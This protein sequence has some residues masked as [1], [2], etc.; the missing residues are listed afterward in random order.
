MVMRVLLALMLTVTSL[1]AQS[2][3]DKLIPAQPTHFVTDAANLFPDEAEK[4]MNDISVTTQTRL[5]GDIAV[6]TL[7][8]IGDYQPYEVAMTAGR[9]WKV[10][11]KGP[12]GS[13]Q[14]NLGV[15]ILVVP[16]TAE[17][18]GECFIATGMGV[19]GFITDS[20][21]G[22]ICGDNIPLFKAGN[23]T[24]AT[25]NIMSTVADIMDAHVNPP[26]P[27]PPFEFPWTKFWILSIVGL[28][29][30]VIWYYNDQKRME[31]EREQEKYRQLLWAKEEAARAER[32]RLEAIEMEKRRKEAERL[33]K[34]RWDSLTPEQQA[35]ELA[36]KE[37]LRLEA[38]E[39]RKQEEEERRKRDE[40]RRK[41][42]EEDARRR[43]NSS[44][45]SYNSFGSGGS[46]GSSGGS[47]F[48][49][50]GGGGGFSGGG[51][52]RSF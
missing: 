15:V 4:G 47:S 31:K 12:V 3:L 1:S 30:L 43:R 52:G 17:H 23:Y 46:F 36:E 18:K 41:R 44:T 6:L 42:D 48:G 40:E 51:G 11:G 14:R 7:P 5:G 13:Q 10:G 45:T 29:V 27:P 22:D 24:Q 19:E 39:R 38:E 26:P 33:E 37:R 28:F 8:D 25:L 20:R 21:A 49:G 32:R 34:I 2:G 16:R 50:F 35:A 9:K